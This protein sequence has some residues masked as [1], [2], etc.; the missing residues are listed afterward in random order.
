[1]VWLALLAKVTVVPLIPVTVE[2]RKEEPTTSVPARGV[3]C[4]VTEFE[5][6]ELAA[7]LMLF[8]RPENVPPPVVIR[9]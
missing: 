7:T 2:P 4:K 6:V 8:V 5:L 3:V 9:L 1:M